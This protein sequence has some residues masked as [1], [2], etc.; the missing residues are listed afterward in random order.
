MLVWKTWVTLKESKRFDMFYDGNRFNKRQKV[1]SGL[2]FLGIIP[3]YI[4]C[5]NTKY[6]RCL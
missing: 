6:F 1:W 4:K 2:F 5:T 3:L